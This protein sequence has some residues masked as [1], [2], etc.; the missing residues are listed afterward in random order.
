MDS[1]SRRLKKS[2]RRAMSEAAGFTEENT[3]PQFGGRVVGI[4]IVINTSAERDAILKCIRDALVKMHSED[5]PLTRVD[6]EILSP[7]D[8]ASVWAELRSD[9]GFGDEDEDEDDPPDT[10]D[11]FPRKCDPSVN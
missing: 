4:H 5:A 6:G 2:E 10:V 8:A 3:H 1:I 9:M 7:E 11:G